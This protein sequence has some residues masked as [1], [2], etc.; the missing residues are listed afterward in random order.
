MAKASLATKPPV[1]FVVAHTNLST[2][3]SLWQ[4]QQGA[5][6]H[7]IVRSPIWKCSCGGQFC[8][9]IVAVFRI[10][11]PLGEQERQAELAAQDAA[12]HARVAAIP[13]R[14]DNTGPRIYR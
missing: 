9:A 12:D 10:L 2:R 1:T 8:D 13:L 11:N 14:R 4:M 3:A 7:M 5:K 6:K